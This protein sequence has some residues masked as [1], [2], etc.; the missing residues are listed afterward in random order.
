MNNIPPFPPA[1]RFGI[2]MLALI[3][4]LAA[5]AGWLMPK[6][7][8]RL[9]EDEVRGL[10][11]AFSLLAAE[12]AKLLAAAAEQAAEIPPSATEAGPAP[13]Q[14]G[15]NSARTGGHGGTSRPAPSRP[16]KP[17]PAARPRDHAA[18]GT[19]GPQS[20]PPLAR[21][22]RTLSARRPAPASHRFRTGKFRPGTSP[23]LG[24]P[25]MLRYRN[26]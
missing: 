17:A 18:R 14:A 15:R 1:E 6:W 3:H 9:M 23:R 16:P 4:S 22:T 25:L 7:L 5:R 11:E 20:E 12:G 8:V 26:K 10:V 19:A 13:S 24:T 21:G 2:A